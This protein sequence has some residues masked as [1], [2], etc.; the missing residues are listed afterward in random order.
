MFNYWERLKNCPP[1]SLLGCAFAKCTDLDNQKKTSWLSTIKKALQLC[2]IKGIGMNSTRVEVSLKRF[3]A[4]H[5]RTTI[6]HGSKTLLYRE[7]ERN[8]SLCRYLEDVKC[9]KLR[10]AFTKLRISAHP[11]A[12]ETGRYTKPITERVNRLCKLCNNGTVEDEEHFL[13]ICPTF[14]HQRSCLWKE[15]GTSCPN[16]PM[17]PPWHQTVYLLSTEGKLA[18]AVAK[19]CANSLHLRDSM[20]TPN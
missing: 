4:D 9:K 5:W 19:Y 2:D 16:F 13:I 10:H 17:L 12:I 18:L 11:L 6:G 20:L 15:I 3:Y 1:S 14:L 8:L 7:L